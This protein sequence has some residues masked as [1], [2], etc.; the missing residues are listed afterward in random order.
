VITALAVP[1]FSSIATADQAVKIKIPEIIR[2]TAILIIL[3][4]FSF[5]FYSFLFPE[6]QAIF[7]PDNPQISDIIASKRMNHPGFPLVM[8]G[9]YPPRQMP[10][11]KL[12]QLCGNQARAWNSKRWIRFMAIY[13]HFPHQSIPLEVIISASFVNFHPLPSPP[14]SRGREYVSLI[15]IHSARK[16]KIFC[17]HW[18]KLISQGLS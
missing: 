13:P 2:M 7:P 9:V 8:P 18:L 14:P 12:R 5:P 4:L 17:C 3:I 16:R 10:V 6:L 11:I 15:F 1:A